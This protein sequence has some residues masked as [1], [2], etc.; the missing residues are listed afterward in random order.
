WSRSDR[1]P[2]ARRRGEAAWDGV[3]NAST[4]HDSGRVNEA[5]TA[6]TVVLFPGALGDF[7]L[8]LPALRMLRQRHA[9]APYVF[10]V[11]GWLSDLVRLTGVA[12]TVVCLEEAAAVGLF[13]G[14]TPPAWISGRP[15]V[16]SWLGTRDP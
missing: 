1:G 4:E 11:N 9:P 14:A 16:Y 3:A 13:G 8:A 5:S 10:V 12:E 6:R 15:R 2:R 7:L